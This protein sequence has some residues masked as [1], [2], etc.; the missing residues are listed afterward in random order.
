MRTTAYYLNALTSSPCPAQT[1]RL[2][3]TVRGARCEVRGARCDDQIQFVEP[4]E[5]QREAR[6]LIGVY[7][8][9]TAPISAFGLDRSHSGD[10]GSVACC[11]GKNHGP[12]RNPGRPAYTAQPALFISAMRAMPWPCRRRRRVRPTPWRRPAADSGLRHAYRGHH[13]HRGPCPSP[14]P[15]RSRCRPN[16]A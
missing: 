11:C 10:L 4:G 16:R 12:P 9:S 15:C 7:Q 3:A 5:R 14:S 8:Q 2:N 1:I 13:P 6:P